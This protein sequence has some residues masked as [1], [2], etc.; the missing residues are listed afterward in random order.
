M[1]T[2]SELYQ[3]LA[4]STPDVDDFFGPKCLRSP[5]QQFEAQAIGVFSTSMASRGGLIVWVENVFLDS[6]CWLVVST[7]LKNI[8]QN[9]NLPQIG[10]KIKNIWNHHLECHSSTGSPCLRVERSEWNNLANNLEVRKHH[11]DFFGMKTVCREHLSTDLGNPPGKTM[12]SLNSPGPLWNGQPTT[13]ASAS[14]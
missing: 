3:K 6:Q 8:R 14:V 5:K 9:G 13:T 10:V 11:W 12:M 1:G 2:L 4:T 7:P